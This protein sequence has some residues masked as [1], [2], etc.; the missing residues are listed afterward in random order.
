MYFGNCRAKTIQGGI[1]TLVAHIDVSE[2]NIVY[3]QNAAAYIFEV[4][5]KFISAI[6]M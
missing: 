5:F 3:L 6:A 4:S 2:N 1:V